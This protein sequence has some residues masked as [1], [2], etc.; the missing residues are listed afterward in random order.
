[1]RKLLYVLIVLTAIPQI[2]AQ[3]KINVHQSGSTISSF[4]VTEL[5]SLTISDDQTQMQVHKNDN[6]KFSFNL[7]SV[8]SISFDQS[9]DT[10]FVEYAN[11]AVN[12]INPYEGF[13]VTV[14]I[15]GADVL[16]NS[17]LTDSQIYYVLSGTSTEGSFKIYSAYRAGLVL[18]GLN[19][20]NSD[21]PAINIQSSKYIDVV[22]KDGTSN[23][24][25][26]GANY[27]TSVE[28]QKATFFSEGQLIF[29]GNGS[30]I[31]SGNY[32]HSLCSDDYITI[33]SGNITVANATKDAI[34]ANEKILFH[35]GNMTLSAN[36]DGIEVEG[37]HFTMTGGVLNIS[38]ASA[39]VKALKA[40]S[41]ITIKGGEA[42][43]T[44]TGNQSKAIS[45]DSAVVLSAGTIKIT[46]SGGVVL[47]ALGSG[48]DPSYCTAVKSA[49]ITVDGA[50][51]CI[52][53]TGVSS[54]SF[55]SDGDVN[56]LSGNVNITNSGSGATYTNSLGKIDAYSAAAISSDGNIYLLGGTLT[57]LV[58]GS[59]G[60]GVSAIGTLIFGSG[61]TNPQATISTTGAKF[62]VSSSASGVTM[63]GGG[64]GG[65]TTATD[66]CLPK[67]FKADGAISIISGELNLNSADDG[68]KS[69]T[70]ISISGGTT[71]INNSTEGIESKI[72]TIEGGSTYIT[73]SDDG[74]NATM[75]TVSGGT[76]SNDGSQV[77]IKGGFI[78]S[79]ISSDSGG[80]AID[81]NGNL[82]YTGGVCMA[83]GP[84]SGANED[85]DVNGNF[86]ANGGTIMGTS[87]T[88]NMN[89]VWNTASTQYA[90]YFKNSTAIA[91]GTL[92]HIRT[93]TGVE[94]AT[95]QNTVR[96]TYHMHFSSPLLTSGLSYQLYVGG[97]YTGGTSADGIYTGGTYTLGTLKSTFTLS[98]K[99][100]TISF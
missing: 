15:S 87:S 37:G 82:T 46:T 11:G 24:L 94:I 1:M 76:E 30:L 81:S 98:S 40:D 57:A 3:N 39:D 69:E 51:I 80:D 78:K 88:S 79:I 32:K 7:S 47:E 8:D 13:G 5:D 49:K 25:T 4:Y 22:L 100:S 14:N 23:Y 62:A 53:Q 35:G 56:I 29:T 66:Y 71:K 6:S 41:T 50:D 21:G 33:E 77:Y 26:D 91:S 84:G 60:K 96:S 92:I 70:S 86:L 68:I 58:S 12:V 61:S 93:A 95:F 31:L 38:L 17:T 27:A 85:Y 99:S 9:G 63:P 19:L 10:V 45:A 90:I 83:V 42:T 48:Y 18:N 34:H 67:T 89:E 16:V 36:G 73:A 97:S 54:K 55:S 2:H 44:L 43:L 52:V 65:T 28:D 59:G 75:S 72:I 20:T 74:I 64:G